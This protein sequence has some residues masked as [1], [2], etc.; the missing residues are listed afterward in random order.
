MVNIYLH[1]VFKD[2]KSTQTPW[3]C[4]LFLLLL[5]MFHWDETLQNSHI[6]RKVIQIIFDEATIIK[7]RLL[8]MLATRTDLSI[9]DQYFVIPCL[10]V[11]HLTELM[12]SLLKSRSQALVNLPS[13]VI[14]AVNTFLACPI[15][16]FDCLV[17]T[18][19]YNHA[20][21]WWKP[22]IVYSNRKIVVSH[23]QNCLKSKPQHSV[24]RHCGVIKSY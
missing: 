16:D 12:I 5:C 18:C 21:I 17:I 4:C 20:T 3:L 15:P 13:W 14:E 24:E 22:D 9:L 10:I 7:G 1:S 8:M 6:W 19:R 11:S 23:V 2:R